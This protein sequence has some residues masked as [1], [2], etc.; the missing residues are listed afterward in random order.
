MEHGVHFHLR[1]RRWC[2]AS[3]PAPLFGMADFNG[4]GPESAQLRAPLYG[5]AI[6][7][8]RCPSSEFLFT[9]AF[10]Q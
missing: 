1:L 2:L 5:L 3:T 8:R 6:Y 4:A 7:Y 10:D 9:D